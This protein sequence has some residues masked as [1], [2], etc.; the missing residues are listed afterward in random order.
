MKVVINR[1]YSA[2]DSLRNYEILINNN[3]VGKIEP[4]GEFIY[5]GENIKEILIKID[6]CYSNKIIVNKEDKDIINLEV[7]SNISGYKIL[8]QLFYI[9]FLRKKYLKLAKV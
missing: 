7:S 9:T 3:C 2:I 1:K 5:D 6:W 4:K 8:F